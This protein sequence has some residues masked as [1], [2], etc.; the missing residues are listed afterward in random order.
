MEFL[1]Y[2]D[3]KVKHTYKPDNYNTK[4]KI[5]DIFRDHWYSFLEDNPNL[6]ESSLL[7]SKKTIANK[8]TST[9]K[10]L[11][12]LKTSATADKKEFAFS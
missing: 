9:G 6:K 1:E 8:I 2:L 11:K 10:L 12:K 4:F 7:I 5:K 3:E